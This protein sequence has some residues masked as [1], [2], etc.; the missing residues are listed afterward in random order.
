MGMM[1]KQKGA[2]AGNGLHTLW[3]IAAAI[4]CYA[5]LMFLTADDAELGVVDEFGYIVDF[6]ALWNLVVNTLHD[7]F[8]ARVAQIDKAIGV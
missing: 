7:I 2:Q 8:K 4:G 5:M 3:M 6:I 1:I